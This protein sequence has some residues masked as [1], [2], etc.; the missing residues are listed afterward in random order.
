MIFGSS[1]HVDLGYFAHFFKKW[2][3]G[4]L[5]KFANFFACV[6]ISRFSRKCNLKSVGSRMKNRNYGAFLVFLSF[7][8]SKKAVEA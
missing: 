4:G 6:K 3:C 1:L 7:F 2:T 8:L 5:L